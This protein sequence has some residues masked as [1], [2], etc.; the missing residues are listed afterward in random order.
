LKGKLVLVTGG[1]SFIASHLVDTLLRNG[2][3]VRV[4][5]DFSSGKLENLNYPMTEKGLDKWTYK[6]LAVHK[7]YGR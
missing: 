2:A 1:A 3:D 7:T 4:A 5:D 6:N